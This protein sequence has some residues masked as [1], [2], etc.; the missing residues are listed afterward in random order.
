M[1]SLD[2]FFCFF[3]ND[4][5][6]TEIYTLSLHDALPILAS[7]YCG[8]RKKYQLSSA[9]RPTEKSPGPRPPNHEATNTAAKNTMKGLWFGFPPNQG[10]SSI[11]SSRATTTAAAAA[12][13]RAARECL[14]PA[15]PAPSL[16]AEVGIA[17]SSSSRHH[18]PW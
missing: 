13:K 17:T 3:F 14:S 6:T 8:E 11:W 4:T 7:E 12:A 16:R 9:A 15:M 5:A 18:S 2:H 10:T 1:T